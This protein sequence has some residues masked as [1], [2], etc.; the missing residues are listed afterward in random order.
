MSVV[1]LPSENPDHIGLTLVGDKLVSTVRINAD[2]KAMDGFVTLLA[3]ILGE[4]IPDYL[5]HGKDYE[6]AVFVV[7]P[8]KAVNPEM[9]LR[10]ARIEDQDELEHHVYDTVEDALDG[11]ARLVDQYLTENGN[12]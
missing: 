8:E 3:N 4:E 11:H 9:D 5:G 6:S 7:D 12:A 10:D 1:E 2:V